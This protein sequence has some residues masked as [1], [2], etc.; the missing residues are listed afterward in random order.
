ML[1]QSKQISQKFESEDVIHSNISKLNKV[2]PS[3][4]PTLSVIPID[5]IDL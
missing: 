1:L 3:K 4:L 2:S 5:E